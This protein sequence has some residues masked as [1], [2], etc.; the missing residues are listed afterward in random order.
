MGPC[1]TILLILPDAGGFSRITSNSSNFTPCRGK[2][3]VNLVILGVT[4]L[5]TVKFPCKGGNLTILK[6]NLSNYY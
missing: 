3:L 4:S 1:S 2:L 6:L 5:F